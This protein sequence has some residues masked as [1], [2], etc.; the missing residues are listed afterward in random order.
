[1]EGII[2]ID[3]VPTK[4]FMRPELDIVFA[5]AGFTLT[6]VDKVEYTWDTELA[7][8]TPVA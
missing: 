6:K 1:V 3:G 2:Y 7:A 4:H 5:T 8:H